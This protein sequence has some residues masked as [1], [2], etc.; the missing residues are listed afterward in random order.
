MLIIGLCGGSGSGK[1][2]VAEYFS[3]YN[4]PSIDAD[5]VYRDLLYPGSDLMKK[6]IAEFGSDIA[7]EDGKL[8]RK[9]LSEIVFSDSGRLAALPKL[10]AIT[11]T[12]IISETEKRILKLGSLGHKA[13]IFDAPQLFESNFDKK[14]DLII[15]VG[16]DSE[17]RLKRIMER[18]GISKEAAMRRIGSQLDDDYIRE[19]S[20]YFLMNNTSKEDLFA[21][22]SEIKDIILKEI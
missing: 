5:A 18:D 7:N 22:L 10:N 2:I 21:N 20:D 9:R 3:K 14:C 17:I 13:V 8:D 15:G 19:R 1:S 16:A 11:H 4:V 6:L 12:A